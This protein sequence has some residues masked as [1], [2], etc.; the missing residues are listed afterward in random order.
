MQNTQECAFQARL[1]LF[2]QFI[3]SLEFSPEENMAG[4]EADEEERTETE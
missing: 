1:K 2:I 3:Q 4:S